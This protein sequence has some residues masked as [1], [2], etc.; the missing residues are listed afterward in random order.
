MISAL[1]LTPPD[2]TD[3]ANQGVAVGEDPDDVGAP[4]DLLVQSLLYP[5]LGGG[6]TRQGSDVQ[7]SRRWR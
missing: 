7:R 3:E 4:P 2:G 5:A 6:S 1:M